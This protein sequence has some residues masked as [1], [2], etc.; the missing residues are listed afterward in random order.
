MAETKYGKYIVTK[1]VTMPVPPG[2]RLA[3]HGPGF[4]ER[5][6][7]SRPGSGV[8]LNGDAVPGCPLYCAIQRTWEVPQPQPFLYAHKHDDAD[9]VILFVATG[10]DADL[11]TNVTFEMGEEGEK[12]V[13]SE[14]TAVYVPKGVTHGPIWYSPFKD[15]REFYL[16]TFLMLPQYPMESR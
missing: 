13:F 14:T 2:A 4:N 8:F 1:P 3:F 7:P 6:G 10:P 16:I 15:N 5:R 11:G 9:E 12:H